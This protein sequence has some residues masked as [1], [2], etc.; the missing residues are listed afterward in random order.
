MQDNFDKARETIWQM[1]GFQKKEK[2]LTAEGWSF[3]TKATW[4]IESISTDDKVA[5][6]LQSISAD[7]SQRIAVPDDVA[8]VIYR[9]YEL[10]KDG[11][12]KI[13]GKRAAETRKRKQSTAPVVE[14]E[15]DQIGNN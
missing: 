13:A 12:R 4:I 14:T 1:P 11:R 7:G 3:I 9:H 8:K 5:I 2:T 15:T 10:L 6:F